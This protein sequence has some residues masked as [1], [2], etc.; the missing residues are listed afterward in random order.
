[1]NSYVYVIGGLHCDINE[2]RS[3]VG[4]VENCVWRLHLDIMKWEKLDIKLPILTYFH[5]SCV[6]DVIL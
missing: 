6:N 2:I 4:L 1:M 3:V 5:A